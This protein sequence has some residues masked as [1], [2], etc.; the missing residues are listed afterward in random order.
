MESVF[1]YIEDFIPTRLSRPLLLLLAVLASFFSLIPFGF[2]VEGE[3]KSRSHRL[4]LVIFVKKEEMM[5]KVLG[6][7]WLWK[8]RKESVVAFYLKF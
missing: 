8:W 1:S 2:N 6:L 5:K 7:I 4:I 3:E